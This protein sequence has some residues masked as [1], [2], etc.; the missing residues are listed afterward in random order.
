MYV[1]VVAGAIVSAPQ[2]APPAGAQRLDTGAW[3]T[4]PNGV[5]TDPLAATCG[6]LPVT[7]VARPA[8]TPT[9]TSDYSVTLVGGI[10][11]DTW[12]ARAKTQGEID[13]ATATANMA[14]LLGKA[15]AASTNNA[16]YLALASPTNAQAVAQ[17]AALTRQVTVL[18]RLA[19]RDLLNST[20]GT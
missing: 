13:A 8:D 18:V 7:V 14:T 5:W 2:T 12:T 3:V 11:T 4:P 17:V 10:P 6:W 16:A 20:D 9:T 1:R 15:D 19:R